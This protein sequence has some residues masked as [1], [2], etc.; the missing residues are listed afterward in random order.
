MIDCYQF[1]LI[2]LNYNNVH[3]P[4]GIEPVDVINLIIDELKFLTP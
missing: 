3:T 1:N 4:A 2:Y